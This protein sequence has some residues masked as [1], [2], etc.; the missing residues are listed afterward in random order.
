LEKFFDELYQVLENS[1]S[2]CKSKTIAL[3]G[4]L[5]S[6]IIAYFLKEKNCKAMA[7]ITKDFV[8]TDLTYCQLTAKKFNIPLEIVMAS[9]EKIFEAIEETVKI[10][11]IFNDIEIRNSIVM[12]LTLTSIKKKGE[13]NVISGDGADELFAGYSFFLKKNEAELQKELE[14]I[15]KI[16]HFPSKKIGEAIGITVETP[17]LNENVVKCAKKIP[18]NLKVREEKGK[19]Y[20][21][22]ILR[23]IFE[24][25]LPTNIVWREKSAM[26]D[27]AGT[28]GLTH[29]FNSV[30]SDDIF[31]SKSKKILDSDKVS[32]RT[33]ESLHYYEIY[34]K[35]F[36][37][38]FKLHTS[39]NKCPHCKYEVKLGTK[40]CRMCGS[41]P[42]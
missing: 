9:T 2:I 7:V 23:K 25:K 36:D 32:L 3:S 19:K 28:I 29:L 8:A 4:G 31:N 40:F 13:S 35:Y 34:R 5:D 12:Y 21:K 41:F 27:G 15:W 22:W 30:I 33:K 24:D 1:I 10:L 26:Q 18:S 16:M 6:S 39:A 11:K 17:F 37:A 42:I 14:R 38:P 20:G